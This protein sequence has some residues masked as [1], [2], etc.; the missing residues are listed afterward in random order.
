[1]EKR[2]V[3]CEDAIV[4]LN[5][6]RPNETTSFI[7]SLPDFSEFPSYS[8]YDWQLWFMKT[9]GLI[10]E[11]TSPDGVSIFFQSDIKHEGEWIDKAFLIQKAAQESGTRLLWHKIFCRVPPGKITFGRPA[12]SHLLCFSKMLKADLS[13]STPDVFDDSGEKAWERGMLFEAC[14][15]SVK[16]VAKE[17]QSNLIINPFCGYGSALA[18]ANYFGLRSIGIERSPKRAQRARLLQVTED[19]KSWKEELD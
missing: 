6:F 11:K 15:E 4:W 12:Y 3:F 7:T 1:M 17:T 16:F 13:R 19:G 10:I 2:I 8:L 5:S 18:M 9:A 14:V